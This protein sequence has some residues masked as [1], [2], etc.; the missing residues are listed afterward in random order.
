MSPQFIV[1]SAKNALG[2]AR[3]FSNSKSVDP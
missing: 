1:D 2:I 3:R